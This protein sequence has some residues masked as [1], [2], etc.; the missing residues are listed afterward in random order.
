MASTAPN[1]LHMARFAPIAS[2]RVMMELLNRDL[3]RNYMF[4]LVHQIKASR[5]AYDNVVRSVLMKYPATLVIID[6]GVIELG[7]PLTMGDVLGE[8]D[9]LKRSMS[10][11][12]RG[13][14]LLRIFVPHRDWIGKMQPTLD[15]FKEDLPAI[16]A[17]GLNPLLIP[18]GANV[19]EVV[20]C[21]KAMAQFANKMTGAGMWGI[22]RWMADKFGSRS[23]IVDQV[24]KIDRLRPIHLLGFSNN[25]WD[26]MACT[27]M[28]G[29]EG[30]DSAV[31]VWW[32]MYARW[33]V[34]GEFPTLEDKRPEDFFDRPG[35]EAQIGSNV[36]FVWQVMRGGNDE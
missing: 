34:A 6:N 29:V 24:R 5:G 30:I 35:Y 18:Q 8:A 31:P 4:L 33:M 27:H 19:S 13:G 7:D 26:D 1:T 25:F 11:A 20:S 21:V 22:P 3:Q 23:Y 10:I 2:P 14:E 32:G 17:A 16:L 9:L 15:A 28:T 12:L 36:E